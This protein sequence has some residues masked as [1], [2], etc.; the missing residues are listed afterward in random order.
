M[1]E[2]GVYRGRAIHGGEWLYG[3]LLAWETHAQIWVPNEN[4]EKRNYEVDP[5]TVG[6]ATGERDKHDAML[7]E[8]DEILWDGKIKGV[9]VFEHG[10]FTIKLGGMYAE[11]T[12]N[13]LIERTGTIH[14]KGEENA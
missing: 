9:V 6:E 12:R 4:G 13:K 7:Y 3:N 5:A 11:I 8:H 14:T 10:A 1:R 2:M